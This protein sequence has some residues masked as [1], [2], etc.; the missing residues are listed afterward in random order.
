MLRMVGVFNENCTGTRKQLHFKYTKI[1]SNHY[2]FR[3]LVDIY[4]KKF[5]DGNCGHGTS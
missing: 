4:N 3:E 5:H 1:F 2:K